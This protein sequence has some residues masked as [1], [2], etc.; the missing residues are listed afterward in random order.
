[1]NVYQMRQIL[2]HCWELLHGSYIILEQELKIVV[3]TV[4]AA[5][6][7]MI[8]T[9]WKLSSNSIIDFRLIN[10]LLFKDNGMLNRLKKLLQKAN[11]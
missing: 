3:K 10:Y 9:L 1:M 2:C 4:A 8:H 6:I 5:H 7:F 11:T